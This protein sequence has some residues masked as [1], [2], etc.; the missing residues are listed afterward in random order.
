MTPDKLFE[1]LAV[2]TL[3]TL[4]LC[5][6]GIGL[7]ILPFVTLLWVLYFAY[8]M[9]TTGWLLPVGFLIA[10]AIYFGLRHRGKT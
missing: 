4:A 1:L 2:I 6:I 8:L 5:T 7:L 9:G 3:V 10:A